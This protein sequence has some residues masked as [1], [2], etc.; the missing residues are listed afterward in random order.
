MKK[1]IPHI[2][3]FIFERAFRYITLKNKI[4]LQCFAQS[5]LA[6]PLRQLEQN[7]IDT[8]FKPLGEG[9]ITLRLQ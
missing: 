5:V 8:P 3:G 1:K 7:H 2:E 6:F 4:Q 9:G